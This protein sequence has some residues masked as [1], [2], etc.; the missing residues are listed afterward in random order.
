MN[1][2]WLSG[3]KKKREQAAQERL[4]RLDILSLVEM[5]IQEKV[6]AASKLG[7]G[8]VPAGEPSNI[9]RSAHAGGSTSLQAATLLFRPEVKLSTKDYLEVTIGEPGGNQKS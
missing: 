1:G 3:R 9:D 2:W 5:N 4:K 7:G 6:M 8:S